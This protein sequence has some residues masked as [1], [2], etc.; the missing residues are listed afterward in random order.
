MN[1][2]ST[3]NYFSAMQ[4]LERAVEESPDNLDF[5]SYLAYLYHLRGDIQ[6]AEQLCKVILESDEESIGA[7]L[8]LADITYKKSDLAASLDL[9]RRA[10]VLK[11]DIKTAYIR[12]YEL[13]KYEDKDLA[14]SYY[15]RSFELE[16]TDLKDYLPLSDRLAQNPAL[17]P[18]DQLDVP[19]EVQ[20]QGQGQ[21]GT[22]NIVQFFLSP[23]SGESNADNIV[24]TNVI[25]QTSVK[26]P[27]KMG[28]RLFRK[29]EG[30][31][32]FA[33]I[34]ETVLILFIGMLIT[35]VQGSRIKK[36]SNIVYTSYRKK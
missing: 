14:N 31:F 34:I 22:D 15:L 23:S 35:L 9:Y 4:E 8:I 5:K 10:V 28:L 32:L 13:L 36:Q 26:S 29:F 11:P 7:I 1:Y 16:K 2:L 30:N 17:K 20:F 18:Q 25:L 6:K 19:R 12:L 24:E 21:S 3:G 27:F 33:K